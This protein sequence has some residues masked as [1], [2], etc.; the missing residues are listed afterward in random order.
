[1]VLLYVMDR[2]GERVRCV[3]EQSFFP[4]V[5]AKKSKYLDGILDKTRRL[6]ERFTGRYHEAN[7]QQRKSFIAEHQVNH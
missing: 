2:Q 4:R 3:E 6:D 5:S 7:Q 1:M